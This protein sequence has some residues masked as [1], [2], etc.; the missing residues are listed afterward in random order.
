M[1]ILLLN[2]PF[3]RFIGLQQD[4]VPLS[5]L[6]VGSH[7]SQEGHAVKI[8]NLEVDSRLS[9]SGY[10]GR[11]DNFDKYELGL[12]TDNEVWT[13]LRKTIESEKPDSI[14]ITVLSVKYKSALKIIN[15]ANE[16]HIDVFVGGPHLM[17]YPNDFG[18]V[19]VLKG[20]FESRGG[21]RIKDL[22]T[23][24]MP[25]Y[26]MLLDD[27][28]PNGY[29]H[30]VSSRGCPFLCKFCASN[31][32]WDRKVT[33]KSASRIIREMKDIRDRF[34]SDSFTFW[35]ETFTIKKNRL[36]EFCTN[37]NIDATWNCDTRADV[38]DEEMLLAMKG[39][40]C[41]HL[42]LGVESGK[43]HILNEIG[44][45]ETL[46]D[47]KRA[48]NLLN[49]H[50][51]Q[52]KAYCIIG[53]PQETEEDIFETIRFIKSLSPFRITLSFFTPYKGTELYDYCIENNIIDNSFDPSQF[54]HQSPHNYFCP[55]ITKERYSEIKQTV[56]S[57][58]D[59][60]NNE[61]VKSWR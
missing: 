59:G 46:D 58:I 12:N 60:Y 4:Y 33:F 24:P 49:K 23:L 40:N 53:F 51:I 8:K 41:Q 61:A 34:K 36:I 57:E 42:S 21:E 39:A 6:A 48:A 14:G 32:M 47:F 19:A 37:Y 35:D 9:Y 11:S 13:E 10:K 25:N 2:P 55:K 16:Y 30:I 26:D 31:T 52:W 28:S 43:Q 20:E 56:S 17:I 38:L 1:K 45:G 50:N 7:L 44:K 29:S 3:Y 18:G 27:Y 5:L 22:D 54:A 15:I